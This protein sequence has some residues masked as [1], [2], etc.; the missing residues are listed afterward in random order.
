MAHDK[1]YTLFSK[2]QLGY[3]LKSQRWLP[4]T[5]AQTNWYHL[6]RILTLNQHPVDAHEYRLNIEVLFPNVWNAG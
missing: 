3:L 1:K 5:M 4:G 6:H 2:G